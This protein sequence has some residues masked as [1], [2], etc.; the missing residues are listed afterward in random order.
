MNFKTIAI[1]IA[2]FAG[3]KFLNQ[4]KDELTEFKESVIVTLQDVSV[5]W[6]NILAPKL[7]LQLQVDNPSQGAATLNDVFATIKHPSTG[8]T[9]GTI[10]QHA[11]IPIEPMGTATINVP[12]TINAMNLV[13]DAMQG[14]LEPEIDIVGYAKANGI[15]VDFEKQLGLPQF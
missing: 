9:F 6:S 2:L 10:N 3:Y 4:K 13:L 15:K 5:D 8:K 14:N 12:I 11:D 7:Y 1:A